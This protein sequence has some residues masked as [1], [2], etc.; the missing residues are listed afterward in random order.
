MKKFIIFIAVFLA[1][2]VN[3]SAQAVING[4]A[5]TEKQLER[6]K[7]I[8]QKLLSANSLP[9]K[10]TF[11]VTDKEEVN[12]YA[13][14]DNEIHVYSGLLNLVETD[15]ELAAVISHEIGHIA[16]RHIQKQTILGMITQSITGIFKKPFASKVANGVGGLSMLK[17]SRTAEYEA[18]LTGADLM[19]GAGYNPQGMLS[20]LNKIAQ[21]YIDVIETHPSGNKR[22]VN[23]YDYLSFN[24]SD[25]LKKDY[26]TDSYRRLKGYITEVVNERN[27]N[28]EKMAAYAQKQTKLRNQKLKRA[29]SIKKDSN[30]WGS[31]Y[32]VIQTTTQVQNNQ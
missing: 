29:R 27:S 19:I 7:V 4:T 18:D 22:L 12:A 30:V 10:V 23:L 28:P 14:I 2:A 15:D 11:Y 24:Y 16:N 21:N 3:L 6:V 5:V 20:L 31:V 13:N 8:G 26:N 17:V 32:N 9:T 1:F 25:K